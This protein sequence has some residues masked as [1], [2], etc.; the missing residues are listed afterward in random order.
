M[1]VFWIFAAIMI[2][3]CF[4]FIL[5]ALL[6]GQNEPGVGYLESSITVQRNRRAE[7]ER[8]Y[9]DGDL[10]KDAY[11]EACRE[12]EAELLH[13]L[14]SSPESAENSPETQ[15]K[16]AIIVAITLPA[17][18]VGLYL[19]LGSPEALMRNA[20]SAAGSRAFVATA[21]ES[22]PGQ[23]PHS[24]EDMVERLAQRLKT[25]PEDPEGWLMLGRSYAAMNRIPAAREALLEAYQR[26]P[27]DPTTLVA[28]AEV[29]AVLN[30]NN[31]AGR[32]TDLVGRA[33]E[34]DPNFVH[35]LWL[36]G[37]AALNQGDSA[38]ATD[39]WERILNTPGI[40]N[41]DASRVQQAIARVKQSPPAAARAAPSE[42]EGGNKAITNRLTINV[43][44]APEFENMVSPQDTL[45]VF[46]R[47][48]EGP[49][50]PLAIVRKTAGELPMT[51][52]LDDSMAMM[53]QMRI[54]A[55]SSVIVSAR[56]SKSRDATPQPGDLS[57]SSSP[58]SPSQNTIV[59][60]VINEVVK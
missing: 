2:G 49:R 18:A 45:F 48:G 35:A 12:L 36:A 10:D 57:G 33:L 6:R 50:M 44:L 17:A 16:T 8:M 19:L 59:D 34:I 24:V 30:G 31:L 15:H 39:Y 42:N 58:V 32:P 60:L 41:S 54:S 5:P 53:P 55:F 46:A 22:A 1:L 14:K 29:E 3:V 28:L 20:G 56:I 51:I 21:D 4:A 23:M 13:E 9:L 40:S 37:V 47:A 52:Q 38:S 25:N 11:D 27:D 43:S 7:L 26:R